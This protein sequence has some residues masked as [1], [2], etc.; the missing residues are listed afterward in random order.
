MAFS[1]NTITNLMCFLNSNYYV[2]IYYEILRINN[3]PTW[4]R[5]TMT[6]HGENLYCSYC[7]LIG[8]PRLGMKS[9]KAIFGINKLFRF[10]K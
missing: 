2:P 1:R 7:Q 4:T 10:H 8:F 6:Y 9:A 5:A 3:A